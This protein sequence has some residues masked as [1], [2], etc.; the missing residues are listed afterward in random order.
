M[1]SGRE[2]FSR[3]IE[4]RSP[5]Y[6]PT[7]LGVSLDWLHEK[8]AA[9]VARIQELQAHFPDDF[10]NWLGVWKNATEPV[11]ENGRKRWFDE[12]GTGWLT[13]GLGWYSEIHP[14]ESG[15]HL[16]DTYSFPNP[17]ASGR[18]DEDDRKLETRGDRYV[19]SM[20]WF[21]IFERLWLLR[22]FENALMDPYLEA[23]NFT[24]LRDMIVEIDLA[25]IDQWLE[26]DV[27]GIFFSDDWGTQDTLLMNPDDWRR[28]Y[29][30]S[31][32]RL[33]RR[34]RDGGAHVWFHACGNITA[35]IP[36]LIDIGM[37]VLNP[38]QPLAMDVHHLACEFGG[39]L[40]F[41][42][43]VDTQMTLTQGTPDEVKQEIHEL[44]RLFGRF[45][46]GYVGAA[47]QSIMPETPLDNIIAFYEAFSEYL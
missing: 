27:D 15:W 10:L 38:V 28:F 40:C 19:Q 35:I 29:K 16:L 45:G 36:D 3:A 41:Y 7:R 24:R 20:V 8:D 22:G 18:F 47:S 17:Y 42:G 43:G 14:L 26:R 1:I 4:F 31:Y 23:A 34:V 5:D 33:F 39:A 44:V 21:T 12:W 25:M 13:D 37:D 11:E 9:K 46:G 30:P 6:L 2:N 32:A